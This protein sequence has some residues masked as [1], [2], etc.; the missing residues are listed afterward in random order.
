MTRIDAAVVRMVLSVTRAAA[1]RYADVPTP[2]KTDDRVTKE[3]LEIVRNTIRL[4]VTS[5]YSHITKWKIVRA[6][7]DRSLAGTFNGARQQLNVG[8]FIRNDELKVLKEMLAEASFL[9]IFL[10][11]QL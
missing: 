2:S 1:P 11:E 8:L 5:M 4:P 9:E 3:L 6:R 7:S 10:L